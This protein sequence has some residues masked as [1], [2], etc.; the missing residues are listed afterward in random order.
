M[1]NVDGLSVCLSFDF[2]AVSL[3]I[4]SMRQ[5][6]PAAISRGEFGLVG[7]RRILDL[8]A[9]QS[10]PATFFIPGHTIDSFPDACRAVVD[11]GHEIGHHN[12]CHENPGT[13][14]ADEERAAIERG[15]AAIVR[16][17][18]RRPE[19]F[20]SPAWDHSEAT[21]GLLLDNGFAYDS[22][23]MATDFEPYWARRDDRAPAHGPFI[24]GPRVPIVELPVDWALD[25][26]PYFGLNWQRHHVGLRAPSDVYETWAA[27]FAYALA[28]H[29][30]GVFTLTMHPQII[31]R[32]SRISMLERLVEHMRGS[33]G[34]RFETMSAV[35]RRWRDAHPFTP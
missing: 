17:T 2:D 22:S 24:P 30:G 28:N 32:G 33:P 13:I 20:R 27:E 1:S 19:G 35:A 29:P 21:V 34:V 10:I 7:A 4:G 11:G 6:S 26:W 14:T 16:L 12:Y 31:G 23:L 3:W 9:R 25:D 18:G 8:L 5:Q 15:I